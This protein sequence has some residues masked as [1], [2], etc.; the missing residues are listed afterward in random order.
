MPMVPL[1]SFS[2]GV[3]ADIVRRQRPSTERT[4]FAWQ[5]V[6][7]AAL[8]RATTV[9]LDAGVLTVG[10]KDARWAAEIERA[11]ESILLRMQ[12]LLGPGQVTRL[13]AR[14]F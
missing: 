6:V 14:P 1:Q 9:S 8:A 7:G 5:L 2:A 3:L 10:A 11:R 13:K 4:T 12:H